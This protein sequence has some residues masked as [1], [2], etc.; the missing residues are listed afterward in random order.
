MPTS[1][2]QN[3]KCLLVVGTDRSLKDLK[4]HPGVLTA[5]VLP[6]YSADK[7][8]IIDAKVDDREKK[9]VSEKSHKN[10]GHQRHSTQLF[11]VEQ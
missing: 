5:Q 2:N 8:C 10:E 7:S 3:G 11:P 1:R 6:P 4:L 9:Y